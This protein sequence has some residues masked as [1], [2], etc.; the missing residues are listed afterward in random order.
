MKN[1]NVVKNLIDGTDPN[2]TTRLKLETF[3]DI[4]PYVG[5]FGRYQW[6]LLI[7]LLPY[8]VAYA[9]LYFSQ[10]FLTLVPQEH[11]CKIEELVSSNFT[12]K[13]RM[14]FGIP[15]S[16]DYPYYD[17]CQRRDLNFFPILNHKDIRTIE[18]ETNKTVD[19]NQWEYNFTEIPYASIAA[20]VKYP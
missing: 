11:W 10:F 5:D 17:R 2:K 9:T 13:E 1:S 19:C 6:L 8:S 15:K 20:E 16:Q 3:D 12:Q 14:E 4:L 7:A 18:W